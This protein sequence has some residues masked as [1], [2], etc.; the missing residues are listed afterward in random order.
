MARPVVRPTDVPF[1]WYR[2][3]SGRFSPFICPTRKGLRSD[4]AIRAATQRRVVAAASWGDHQNIAT[5]HWGKTM[6]RIEA[7]RRRSHWSGKGKS[8]GKGKSIFGEARRHGLEGQCNGIVLKLQIQEQ[9]SKWGGG[10][11]A[12]LGARPQGG[13]HSEQKAWADFLLSIRC[14]A[15]L[16]SSTRNCPNVS[17]FGYM[18][19][20]SAW[21]ISCG[22]KNSNFQWS[23]YLTCRLGHWKGVGEILR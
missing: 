1:E 9:C 19:T 22:E 13:S 20:V 4:P 5:S 8:R 14:L 7:N 23:L 6:G 12:K 15:G 3:K 11:G 21:R 18:R 16:L 17:F 10:A 2:R